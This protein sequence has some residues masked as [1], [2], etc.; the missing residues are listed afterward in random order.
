MHR[1][2][3]GMAL[4]AYMAT[5]C[6][7]KICYEA[8]DNYT[9]KQVRYQDSL[10]TIHIGGD[11]ILPDCIPEEDSMPRTAM[12]VAVGLETLAE[13]VDVRHDEPFDEGM[14]PPDAM[15]VFDGALGSDCVDCSLRMPAGDGEHEL[16]FSTFGSVYSPR[17]RLRI[18]ND[19]AID[20]SFL[21]LMAEVVREP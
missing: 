20:A 12:L 1:V 14:L 19:G 3:I 4:I 5:G 10:H 15:I 21:F 13:L 2:E 9:M 8:E 6:M 16:E 18:L 11:Q 17:M 7:G